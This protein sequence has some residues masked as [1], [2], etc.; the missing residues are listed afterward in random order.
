MYV[1]TRSLKQADFIY[2]VFKRKEKLN[3][4][5]VTI[6]NSGSELRRE[7]CG[8]KLS[9]SSFLVSDLKQE[10]ISEHL[11]RKNVVIQS[12]DMA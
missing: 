11:V 8:S 12:I 2:T 4:L 7:K 10:Q 9:S 5:N 6:K 3:L 1:S